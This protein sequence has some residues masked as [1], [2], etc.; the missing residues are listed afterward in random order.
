M[1][2]LDA[3]SR[4]IK[5]ADPQASETLQRV[6]TGEGVEIHNQTLASKVWRDGDGVHV[7]EGDRDFLQI[8]SCS[9][10]AVGPI[11]LV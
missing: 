6:L 7:Q 9:V 4:L 10:L 1:T 5:E 2:L 3:G 8:S 11:Q